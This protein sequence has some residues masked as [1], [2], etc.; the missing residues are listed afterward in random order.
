MSIHSAAPARLTTFLLATAAVSCLVSIGG[1]RQ[2]PEA[3]RP[4]IIY[5]MADDLGYGDLGSYG[6]QIIRTPFLDKMA[7]EGVRLTDHYSGSPVCAP[8]R[9]VLMTG[10]HSGHAVVRGN[11]EVSP[12]GQM[13]LPAEA[14]TVA[15]LLKDAG[16]VTGAI[17]KWGL[18]GPGSTGEPND[19]GFDYWYGHLCQRRAHSYYPY[20]VWRN[21]GKVELEGNDPIKQQ[22]QYIHDLFT[23]EALDFIRKNHTRPFFLYLPYTIP[24]LEYVA[25]EDSMAAYRGKFP[26]VPFEGTGYHEELPPSPDIPFPGNYGPQSHSRAAY[27]AMITRM[28]GDIGRILDLLKQLGIDENTLVIFTSDNGAAQGKSADAEFFTSNGPLRGTKG[29]VY[30]GGIRVPLI[31][32]WPGKIKPGTASDH[33]SAFW[34]FLPT[35]AELAGVDPGTQT[36]GISY[37]PALLGR[38]DAQRKHEYLYWEFKAN[39]QPMQAVRMGDWKAIML[40]GGPIALF[41]L[42]EDAGEQNDVSGLHP[43]V[44]AKAERYLKEARTPSTDFPLYSTPAATQ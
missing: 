14:S 25:P 40:D 20:Y 15:E 9:C 37:L 29:T 31:A 32:R 28:D 21:K 16:Y 42:R 18:G 1:C 19:Q 34:D 38:R 11:Y 36:D 23:E 22:G 26:E 43:D 6:Q 5:I 44:V 30:E 4:S 3:P 24:H 33:P 12:E 27:A 39:G 7:A 13:P 2:A 41:N 17:G 35:A 8:S 10:L